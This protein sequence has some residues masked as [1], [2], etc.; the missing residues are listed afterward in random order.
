MKPVE[1]ILFT[2]RNCLIFDEDGNQMCEYQ[3]KISHSHIDK[4]I[5]RK[6]ISEAKK[7]SLCKFR[8]W[9]HEISVDDMKCLLGVHENQMIED[10]CCYGC[11]FNQYDKQCVNTGKF[12]KTDEGCITCGQSDVCLYY[13]GG[14]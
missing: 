6:V 5:A 9:I 12:E 7:F 10:G 11:G 13:N 4:N 8:E 1:I 2:N 3:S 14:E